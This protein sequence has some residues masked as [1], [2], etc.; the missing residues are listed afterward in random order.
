MP[1]TLIKVELLAPLK[2]P[3]GA[4]WAPGER[5]AF[6]PADAEDLIKR[7]LAKRVVRPPEHKMVDGGRTQTK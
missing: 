3:M 1:S 7:G 6:A 2:D 4:V 5:A